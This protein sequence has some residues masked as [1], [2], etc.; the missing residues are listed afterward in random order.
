[1]KHNWQENLPADLQQKIAEVDE[2]IAPRLNEINEVSLYNQQRVL[3]LFRENHVAEEDLVGS[4]GYGYDDIGRDK[5]EKI[6]AGYFKT[7][8]AL[9][10]P[11]LTSGTHAIATALF[12]QLYYGDTLYYMT[13]TP[14]DTIQEVIG[15]AGNKRGNMKEYGID[16]K[17]TELLDDGSVDYD[18]AKKRLTR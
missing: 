6:Y 7:E 17:A 14:Y 12:S 16:F 8:D 4:T 18:Q 10:R 1:M 11:Q 5:L 2:M 15:L 13:G 9:V 3:N